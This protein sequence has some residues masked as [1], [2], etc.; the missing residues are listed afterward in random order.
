VKKIIKKALELCLHSPFARLSLLVA[1]LRGSLNI[2]YYMFS[3]RRITIR[4]PF[5]VYEKVRIKGPGKVF[6]DK[7]CSVYP[8]A[9]DGL[10]ITTFASSAEVRIGQRCNLG[11]LTVRCLYRIEI[12]DETM[13]ANCLIQDKL[14]IHTQI[15]VQPV[16]IGRNVW[17]G[18]QSCLLSGTTVGNDAV[19]AAGSVCFEVNIG[20]YCLGAGN[21]VVRALPIGRILSLKDIN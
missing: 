11:G 19:I 15:P 12:G 3:N 1:F 9:F 16:N 17:I 8:N 4:F 6:I 21:P 7:F 5:F 20:D 2:F 10:S 14:T 13:T 18:A